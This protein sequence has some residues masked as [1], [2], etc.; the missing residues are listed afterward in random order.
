[1]ASGLVREKFG[2]NAG[3]VGLLGAVTGLSRRGGIA[4]IRSHADYRR[5][6]KRSTENY[7]KTRQSL[8]LVRNALQR[9]RKR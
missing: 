6:K 8:A 9:S 2:V 3:F 5:A 4:V 7:G 1:M